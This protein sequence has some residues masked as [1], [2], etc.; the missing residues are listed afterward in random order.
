VA[1][2]SGAHVLL[3][4]ADGET[5]LDVDEIEGL[6][7]T[8]IATRSDLNLAEQEAVTRAL[9]YLRRRPHSTSEILSEPFVRRLH[10]TM[11][12]AV[13]RWAGAYRRTDKN[14]GVSWALIPQQVA[15]L[16]GDVGYWV[17]HQVYP[18]DEI[19]V[20]VHH[21]A[22]LIHPFANGNGRHTRLL[23]DL[24]VE[25][26]GGGVFTWGL[27]L[28]LSPGPLRGAYIAALRAAD[29]GEIDDLLRFAKA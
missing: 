4:S 22:V 15:L 2:L 23:A 8:W 20:R 24:L 9:V 10:R 11:F 28:G 27:N 1:P 13:W 21:R 17:E 16:V 6:I 3:G 25:S 7:P 5:P 14:I 18:P 29:A 26:L 19:A 12:R